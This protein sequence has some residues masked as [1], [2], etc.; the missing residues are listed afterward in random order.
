MPKYDYYCPSCDAEES[1]EQG[2]S[3]PL[4]APVCNEHGEMQQ[5]YSL[6]VRKVFGAGSSP[7]RTVKSQRN[8]KKD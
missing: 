1:F 3:E 6:G 8:K 5:D 4:V 7:T 2:Y